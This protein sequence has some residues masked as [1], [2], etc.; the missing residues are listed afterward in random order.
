MV[1]ALDQNALA[2]SFKHAT[3]LKVAVDRVPQD[4]LRKPERFGRAR[5]QMLGKRVSVAHQL[6]VRHD[7]VDQ[8][9][10]LGFHRADHLAREDKL[11]CFAI[12]NQ[13]YEP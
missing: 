12:T 4:S 8:T 11:L 7:A 3:R 10:A 2:E 6:V 9:Y 5:Q 1:L 13:L